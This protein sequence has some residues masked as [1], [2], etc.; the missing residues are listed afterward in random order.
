MKD[1]CGPGAARYAKFLTETL[2]PYVDNNLRTFQNPESRVVIGSSLG[3]LISFYLAWHH[4]DKFAKAACLSSTFG[5]RSDLYERVVEDEKPPIKVYLDSGWP[6]DNFAETQTMAHL[7]IA[8]GFELGTELHYV[9][10][11]EAKHSESDWSNRLHLPFQFLLGLGYGD[12][13]TIDSP[14]HP[15]T[16]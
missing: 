2:V 7:M 1:Y 8:N 6:G 9:A 10:V 12:D 11:P 16:P 14:N 13:R 5:Y 3:G 4:F 15:L